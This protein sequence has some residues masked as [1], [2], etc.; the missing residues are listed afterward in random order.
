MTI[1]V[2]C[3]LQREPQNNLNYN[4][5]VVDYSAAFLFWSY[6][7]FYCCG[8]N[9][10]SHDGAEFIIWLQTS[11]MTQAGSA[12]IAGYGTGAHVGSGIAQ[13]VHDYGYELVYRLDGNT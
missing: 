8:F 12:H 10:V 9:Q 1:A 7:L 4:I 5:V 3:E 11:E 13:T 6:V 2:Y